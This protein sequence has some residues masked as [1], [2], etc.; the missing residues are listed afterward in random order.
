MAD[1]LKQS[2]FWT[3]N[4]TFSLADLGGSGNFAE[5]RAITAAESH[6]AN[7][8]TYEEV[9][10][11][12]DGAGTNGD[13]LA[14]AHR[15]ITTAAASGV[16]SFVRVRLRG[17]VTGGGGA[18]GSAGPNVSG[19]PAGSSFLS[20]SFADYSFDLATDPVAGGSWTNAKVNAQT[21]GLVLDVLFND[22]FTPGS[23]LLRVSEFSVELWGPSADSINLPSVGAVLAPGAAVLTAGVSVLS[24][25]SVGAVLTPGDATLSPGPGAALLALE[26]ATVESIGLDEAFVKSKADPNALVNVATTVDG[27]SSPVILRSNTAPYGDASDAT[28]TLLSSPG[29]WPNSGTLTFDFHGTIGSSS[30]DGTGPIAGLRLFARIRP[31]KDAN[32]VL[33]NFRFDF[34]AIDRVLSP[35]PTVY[36]MPPAVAPFDTVVSDLITLSS[37]GVP[38]EWGTTNDSV[39]TQAANGWRFKVDYSVGGAFAGQFAQCEVADAWLE[40]YAVTGSPEE[41]LLLRQTIGSHV[42]LQSFVD[43]LTDV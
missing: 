22:A 19:T 7:D 11:G 23:A 35:Q 10:V 38:F 14:T 27:G 24:L 6:D 12:G 42:R 4:P 17:R 30:V 29:S 1:V 37:N 26:S 36:A 33:N 43:T 40:V 3:G 18:A 28:K 13:L 5:N 2:L 39:W 34:A 25:P 21:W 8:A 32:A 9:A 41:V 16:I 20:G 31:R 15:A